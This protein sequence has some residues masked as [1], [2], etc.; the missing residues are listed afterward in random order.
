VQLEVGSVATPF[1]HRSYGQ[2]L[3]LCQRY[4]YKMISTALFTPFAF[5]NVQSP[6]IHKPFF[7]FPVRLRV[8]PT[9]IEYGD[10]GIITAF[11]LGVTSLNSLALDTNIN[12]ADSTALTAVP[13]SG[14]GSAGATTI[15][16]ANNSSTAFVAFSA[17]L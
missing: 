13:S 8:P 16:L 5:C 15:L 12:G 3:A 1:E 4:Y 17:E 6:T 7:H 14:Q 10:L 2:E 11:G 9:A